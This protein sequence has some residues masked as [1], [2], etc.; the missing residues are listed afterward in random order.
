[1]PVFFN[2]YSGVLDQGRH[3]CTPFRFPSYIVVAVD[4]TR[5]RDKA[6]DVVAIVTDENQ[7]TVGRIDTKVCDWTSQQAHHHLLDRR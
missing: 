6:I 4:R 5:R 2:K 1:M 7:P 3:L